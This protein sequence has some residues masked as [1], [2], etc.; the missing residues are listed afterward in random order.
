MPIDTKHKAYEYNLNDWAK[1][2]AAVKGKQALINLEL[3]APDYRITAS[4]ALKVRTRKER[5][6]DRGRYLNAVGR[7]VEV[8]DGMVFSEEPEVTIPGK[9]EYMITNAGS[10]GS[11]LYDIAQK[12]VKE[13]I[14]LG[15]FGGLV[16]L[17]LTETG[18]TIHEVEVGM[19]V[20]QITTYKAEQICYWLSSGSLVE[21]RLLECY[22]A[23]SQDGLDVVSKEQ[24]RRLVMAD[25][26]YH[27]QVWRENSM[28]SDVEPVAN[29]KKMNYIP[30]AFLGSESNNA[31]VDKIPMLDL[32]DYNIGHFLLD[33]DNREN[34]HYHGQGMTNVYTGMDT[35]SF[36]EANPTGLDVG[37]KGV[38]QLGQDDRVEIL[39]MEATGAIS[40]EM[41]L[42]EKRIIMMGGQLVIDSN[43]NQTL[44]A[45]TMEFSSSTSTLKKISQNT[46]NWM[47]TLIAYCADMLNATGEI[48]Y[49]LNKVFITD[50]MDPAMVSNHLQ[51]VIQGVLPKS[52]FNET[53]RE[54][55][56]TDKSD[57][58]IEKDLQDE[59]F[60]TPPA[61]SKEG[62]II[63]AN[64]EE[65]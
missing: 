42:D 54:V 53:A 5:Y 28:Y 44:G 24:V 47:E 62:A 34:L 37:A 1:T 26:V 35:N 51:A 18:Q 23:M 7:T 52:T 15:R 56:F 41:E 32:A 6:F 33:C 31:E 49:Q 19:N 63:A 39:Q 21:V 55:G 38:N 46:S 43:S 45:K 13:N 11:S 8:L 40:K 65:E 48:E 4:N 14:K 50:L 30:F 10:D 36:N 61:M 12:A 64:T 9:L 3:I 25:G 59:A 57:E 20:P 27:N 17:P 60:V 2:E 16:D 29:G 58:D 22:D